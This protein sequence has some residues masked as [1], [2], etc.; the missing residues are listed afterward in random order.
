MRFVIG[1]AF[2]CLVDRRQAVIAEVRDDGRAGCLRFLDTGQ[3]QW[4]LWAQFHSMGQ[5]LPIGM[6]VVPP[7]EATK[8]PTSSF[9]D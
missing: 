5:W 1:E 6:K 4:V 7:M 9:I 3:Q 8:T 2:E